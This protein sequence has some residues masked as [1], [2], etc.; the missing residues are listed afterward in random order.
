MTAAG[1]V[2]MAAGSMAG[3][4]ARLLVTSPAAVGMAFYDAFTHLVE[5]L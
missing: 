4:T 5:Y 2:A 3:V 1:V